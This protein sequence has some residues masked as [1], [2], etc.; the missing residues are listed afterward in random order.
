M[1]LIGVKFPKLSAF[2]DDEEV[3]EYIMEDLMTDGIWWDIPDEKNAY[4]FLED[5]A[6]VQTGDD[7]YIGI[8]HENDHIS[9][10]TIPPEE[11][12]RKIDNL[13]DEAEAAIR[14]IRDRRRM[15]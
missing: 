10:S 11:L 14:K 8:R 6:K 4:Y 3:Q 9:V 15:K 5:M 12:A 7:I 2:T 1:R 13:V